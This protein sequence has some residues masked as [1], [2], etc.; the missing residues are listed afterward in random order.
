MNT[1][2]WVDFNA[3]EDGRCV[4]LRKFVEGVVQPGERVTAFDF[5]G[6]ACDGV[7]VSIDD[8]RVT[9]ALDG[10]ACREEAPR[11]AAATV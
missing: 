5:D 10:D 1:R 3:V 2:V 8:S 6:L 9:I 7:V 11:G 4:T